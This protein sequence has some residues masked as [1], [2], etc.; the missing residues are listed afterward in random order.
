MTDELHLEN[1]FSTNV[2]LDLAVS[3]LSKDFLL[4]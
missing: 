3:I 1:V 2:T 4:E